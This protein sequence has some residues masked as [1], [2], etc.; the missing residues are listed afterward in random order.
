ALTPFS[1]KSSSVILIK[2]FQFKSPRTGVYLWRRRVF[3]QRGMFWSKAWEVSCVESIAG[4]FGVELLL[5]AAPPAPERETVDFEG[6]RDVESALVGVAAAVAVVSLRKTSLGRSMLMLLLM[7]LVH[8]LGVRISRARSVEGGLLQQRRT[9]EGR[10]PAWGQRALKIVHWRRPW[11]FLLVRQVNV[12]LV[13]DGV[14]IE[15]LVHRGHCLV[16][17]VR[18][19]NHRGVHVLELESGELGLGVVQYLVAQRWEKVVYHGTQLVG[20]ERVDP[21]DEVADVVLEGVGVDFHGAQR[22]LNGGWAALS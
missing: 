12:G 2:S 20:V 11:L 1:F 17:W 14:Q 21:V 10:V 4:D 6:V 16:H 15:R 18:R 3:N 13:Q 22:S 19:G 7:L 8:Q 9:I 5:L